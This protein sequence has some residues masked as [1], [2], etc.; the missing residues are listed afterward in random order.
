[1]VNFAEFPFYQVG[2]NR[3]EEGAATRPLLLLER[4][5][6]FGFRDLSQEG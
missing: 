3:K 5:S 2:V 6:G 1:L 4:L